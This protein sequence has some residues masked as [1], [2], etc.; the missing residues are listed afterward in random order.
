VSL[1][2]RF[3]LSC[4]EGLWR[5]VVAVSRERG[6]TVHT[7]IAEAPSEG[8]AV[9]ASVG[10]TAARYF[11]RQG[12]LGPRF[13]GAHGVWL[14]DEELALLARADAA[15]VHCPGSNM[16][17]GSGFADVRRWAAAGIRRGLGSDGAACNNRLDSFHEMSLAAGLS[18]VL[19]PGGHLEARDIVAM[20]TCEGARALGLGD[21]IGSL[22][23]GK[24][25]DVVVV[26]VSGPHHAPHAADVYTALV[27]SARP[28]DV[29]LTAVAG[30]VLFRGGAW[31]TLDPDRVL[32]DARMESA[33][34][35]R[36]AGAGAGA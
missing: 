5:D 29:R 12:V 19:S 28:D 17:L 10:S 30:R 35:A 2:P 25:A 18:R 15:L 6:M 8:R 33:A 23:A 27:H 11:A 14:D 32:G 13:V 16:K 3:I 34:L 24:Q 22:E 31:C 20:A 26:D 9:Q 7:H 36:R 21:S 4:S 1:A